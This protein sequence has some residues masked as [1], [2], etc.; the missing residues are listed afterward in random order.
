MKS[1][2]NYRGYDAIK[3][4]MADLGIE[5]KPR[6]ELLEHLGPLKL[7]D[8]PDGT[9]REWVKPLNAVRQWCEQH[10]Y[11]FAVSPFEWQVAKIS[12][13]A[14]VIVIW[15]SKI[16]GTRNRRMKV[17]PEKAYD[18]AACKAAIEAVDAVISGNTG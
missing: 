7:K 15:N 5:P 6:T 14:F 10:G 11:K 17:A 8:L 9:P 2:P 12:S 18:A 3:G 16:K 1:H 4:K 13:D